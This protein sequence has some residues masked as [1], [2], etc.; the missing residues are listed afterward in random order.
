MQKVSRVQSLEHTATDVSSVPD[1]IG[2]T[3]CIYRTYMC[4]CTRMYANVLGVLKQQS[5]V[6]LA[7]AQTRNW[8]TA[9]TRTNVNEPTFICP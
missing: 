1:G 5:R 8:H 6:H 7:R 9:Y 2:F 4:I 3:V